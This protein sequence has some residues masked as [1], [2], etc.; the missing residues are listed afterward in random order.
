M[1]FEVLWAALADKVSELG[2]KLLAALAVLAVGLLLIRWAK[3]WIDHSKSF[4]KI[5]QSARSFLRSVLHV[6]L[7][8]LLFLTVAGILGLPL[9][10]FVT[11]LASASVAVSLA[12]QGA[13]SNFVGGVMILLFHP[14]RVGDYIETAERSGTVKSIT[15]FYTI[16]STVDNK[17]ITIPNGSLTNEAIVNYSA[18][19][20]RRVDL[21]FGVDYGSDMEK[22]KEILLTLAKAH[23]KALQDPEPVA[24]L[25][26]QNASSLDFVLRVWCKSEDYWDL[27][28]DLNEGAKRRFDEEGISI[29]FPQMDV[30]VKYPP[31]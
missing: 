1:D 26:Q 11:I 16:L 9:T 28:F 4:A 29:P 14:F 6:I 22:V 25:I 7:Y 13:L 3:R 19:D 21:T 20:R 15:V 23:P 18:A 27:Y 30:H 2:L 17:Q 24:R 5:D 12:L 10:S 31:A 8:V